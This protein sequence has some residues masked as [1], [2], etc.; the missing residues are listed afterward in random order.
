LAPRVAKG[1]DMDSIGRD[2][3]IEFIKRIELTM[4]GLGEA[5]EALRPV[6]TKEQFRIFATAFADA[7]GELDLGV[8]EIIYRC[9][10]DLRPEGMTKVMTLRQI[11]QG[12][13]GSCRIDA[14]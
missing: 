13:N 1:E 9:H 7:I 8:L 2:T 10:P 3:A 6:L 12:S 14:P 4:N 11:E 5:G